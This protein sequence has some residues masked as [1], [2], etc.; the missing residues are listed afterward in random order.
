MGLGRKNAK[1]NRERNEHEKKPKKDDSFTSQT[2]RRLHPQTTMNRGV[3]FRTPNR[4]NLEKT[5]I[6]SGSFPLEK[7]NPFFGGKIS[8][9]TGGSVQMVEN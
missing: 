9:T 2:V 4:T 8:S 7:T 1:T 6:F 5:P 3:H